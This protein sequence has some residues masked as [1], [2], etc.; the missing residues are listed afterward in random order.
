MLHFYLLRNYQTGM[1]V[2]IKN[3]QKNAVLNIWLVR[4]DI[5]LLRSIMGLHSFDVGLIFLS[6][7]RMKQL[8]YKYREKEESTDIL[9]FPF[10]NTL[11]GKGS[12][13]LNIEELNLGDIFLCPETIKSKYTIDDD[14]LRK[15]LVPL[16][17]HGLCHL[18]GYVHD[19]DKQWMRMNE[20]ET[21]ILRLFSEK[22][23]RKFVPL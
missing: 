7:R 12:S 9:S 22:T 8:N 15:I 21:E 18:C 1:S 6:R 23:K 13:D 4:K 3:L 19:T 2:V 16:I 10:H 5:H 11:F 20:K 14:E 17:T